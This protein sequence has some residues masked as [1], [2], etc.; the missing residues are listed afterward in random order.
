MTL[1]TKIDIQITDSTGRPNPLENVLFGLKVFI[2]EDSWHNYSIFKSNADGHI[3][4]TKQDIIDNTELKWE[5]NIS[6][7]SPTKFELYVWE[8][9]Q[10]EDLVKSTQRLLELYNDKDFLRQDLKRHGFTDENMN[11]ALA[12][13][14]NKAPEDAALY[15]YIKDAINNSIK[16]DTVKIEGIWSDSFKRSIIS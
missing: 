12:S 10:T 14:N 2:D 6:P 1:P 16:I 9:Q 13:I 4:L 11:D 7:T 15:Q 8:G 3:T 5:T